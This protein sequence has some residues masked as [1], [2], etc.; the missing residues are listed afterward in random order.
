MRSKQTLLFLRIF[1]RFFLRLLRPAP[2][3]VR[4]LLL[5]DTCKRCCTY[6][7]CCDFVFIF[8]VMF[9]LCFCFAC[10]LTHVCICILMFLVFISLFIFSFFVGG[11]TS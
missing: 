1:F 2:A 5:C 3:A 11:R 4:V 9:D 7:T 6:E 8:L 10:T